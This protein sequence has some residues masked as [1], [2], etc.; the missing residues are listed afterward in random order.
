MKLCGACCHGLS[1]EKFSKKQWQL[2]QYQRRCKE[3]IDANREVQLKPPVKNECWIC[4]DE[5]LDETGEP[6]V[7]D[8]SC[9]GNSGHA[10]LSCIVKY[11]EQKSRVVNP[12]GNYLK[13]FIDPWMT[14]PNCL[15]RYQ[16]ELAF[17]LAHDFS[18]FAEKNYPYSSRKLFNQWLHVEVYG[19][20]LW[21]LNIAMSRQEEA[22]QI[23]ST[24]LS[25]IQQMK[26]E[27]YCFLSP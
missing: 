16:N 10:H 22:K 4:L 6:I 15:Q 13:E 24:I 14:C 8:C 3:C 11:A 1:K 12:V 21:L 18:A 26:L 27:N 19:I 23:A 2:K 25:V 7:R 5:G 17:D 9:R 20:K